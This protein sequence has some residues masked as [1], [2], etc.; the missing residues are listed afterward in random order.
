MSRRKKQY[1]ATIERNGTEDEITIY[2][3]EGR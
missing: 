3:P 1:Y 2:T